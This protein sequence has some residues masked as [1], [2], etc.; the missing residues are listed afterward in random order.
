[1]AACASGNSTTLLGG[2]FVRLATSYRLSEWGKVRANRYGAGVTKRIPPQTTKE[3]ARRFFAG[4]PP[5]SVDYLSLVGL[6]VFDSFIV[7]VVLR[8]A[9]VGAT[10]HRF[11]THILQ[12]RYQT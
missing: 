9:I 12:F 1:M 11:H 7:Q 5:L 2:F 3:A 10:D 8:R 6:S 4:A